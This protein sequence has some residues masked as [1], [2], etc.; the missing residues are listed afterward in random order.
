V[1]KLPWR[2]RSKLGKAG[3]ILDTTFPT[4]INEQMIRA[5]VIA[6][7][8]DIGEPDW[9]NHIQGRALTDD[10]IMNLTAWLMSQKSAT[11]GQPYPNAKPDNDKPGEA[12][13]FAVK[14]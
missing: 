4:L 14:K 6:G 7:R 2:L 13:P 11:P 9:R 1:R 5:P 12:E 10:E 8:P 3:S